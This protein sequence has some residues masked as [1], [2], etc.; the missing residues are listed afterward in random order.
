M[1]RLESQTLKALIA[2]RFVQTHQAIAFKGGNKNPILTM[3]Q[4]EV[5]HRSVPRIKEYGARFQ[6]NP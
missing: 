6:A 2:R 5:I 3:N 1:L 4:F